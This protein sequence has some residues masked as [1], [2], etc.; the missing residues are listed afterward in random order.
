MLFTELALNDTMI[1]KIGKEFS[2]IQT[3]KKNKEDKKNVSYL[4]CCKDGV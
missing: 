2:K 1:G 4:S 3:T